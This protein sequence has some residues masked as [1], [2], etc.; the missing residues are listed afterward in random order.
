[1]AVRGGRFGSWHS[2]E[3]NRTECADPGHPCARPATDWTRVRV[4]SCSRIQ[5]QVS[6]RGSA[7]S[8]RRW[9]KSELL[10]RVQDVVY[11]RCSRSVQA[12]E[13]QHTCVGCVAD[14]LVGQLGTSFR[15]QALCTP[16]TAWVL[17]LLSDRVPCDRGVAV[18]AM[19]FSV[20][21]KP[22]GR[23]PESPGMVS[24]V[25]DACRVAHLPACPA[26][27]SKM[28][29]ELA[30]KAQ[31]QVVVQAHIEMSV[32]PPC[33]VFAHVLRDLMNRCRLASLW[34]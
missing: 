25:T 18:R 4:S 22:T 27:P 34:L 3:H 16:Q 33:Q 6:P 29:A 21:S 23:I 17:S 13:R 32:C 26:V 2:L 30:D 10:E 15:Q 24:G 19:R 11:P 31:Q 28:V 20:Q 8:Q 1:M 9:L 7:P 14:L 5:L 12:V